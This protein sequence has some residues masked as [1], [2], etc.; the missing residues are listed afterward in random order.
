[1]RS[2]SITAL[3]ILAAFVLGLA[4]GAQAPREAAAQ[5]E[6]EI[7]WEMDEGS[8]VLFNNTAEKG[9]L[10]RGSFIAGSNAKVPP[11]FVDG[12]LKVNA[13]DLSGITIYEINPVFECDGLGC[14]SC[15]DLPTLCEMPPR[16][17]PLTQREFLNVMGRRW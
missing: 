8:L 6:P 2:L 3:M 4:L 11:A 16:P 7:G 14:R 9:F 15:D 13:R 12:I 1:M 5:E 17:L 10:S